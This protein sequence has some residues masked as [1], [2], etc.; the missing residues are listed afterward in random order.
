MFKVAREG[1]EI[2]GGVFLVALLLQLTAGIW[3]FW[4][5]F[6]FVLQFFREP[7]RTVNPV[8]NAVLSPADG[9]VVF[10]GKAASPFDGEDYLKISVFMNVFNVHVNR[11]PVGGTVVES[12]RHPGKFFNAEI[13][14]SSSENERHT[15]VIDSECGKVQCVQ[16]AGLLARRILCYPKTGD[17]LR[18]GERY[19]FIR[20]GSRVDVY[21]PTDCQPAVALGDKVLAGLNLLAHTHP[22]QDAPA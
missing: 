11:A 9:R 5:V 18:L 4:V 7:E 3:I 20:F 12:L 16:I 22:R 13:D 2:V 10:V 15:L 6:A 17:Y 14:K 8:E 19:G 21:L 1:W